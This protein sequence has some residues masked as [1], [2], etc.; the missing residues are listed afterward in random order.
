MS[1]GKEF[2][3]RMLSAALGRNVGD[4]AFE[5]LQQRLLH[6][7]TRDVASDRRVL[8]LAANLIDLVDI[9]DALLCAF[10]VAIGRLQK[11]QDD[12]LNVFADVARF[13]QR[14]GID[15]REGHAQHA[16]QRL[17]QQRLAGSG[18][19]NQ[20]DVGFLNLDVRTTAADFDPL[21]VLVDRDRQT[22]LRLVLSDNILVQKTLN[23][24]GLGKRWARRYGLGLLIVGD[25]LIA[26]VDALIADVDG[27]TGNELSSP[28]SA[29]CR[30]MNSATCRRFV[31]PYV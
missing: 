17:R 1:I 24:A 21:V 29:T 27:R 20:K 18:R 12:V 9:D 10:D 8:V 13:S 2:L 11:L 25:D 3:M 5:Y 6:A 16:R 4:R 31:L 23:L 15:N 22:L 19:P 14:G 30:R 26:D 28:R 7:F